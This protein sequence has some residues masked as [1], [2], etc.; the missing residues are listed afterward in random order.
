MALRAI[1]SPEARADVRA[2]DRDPAL[3]ML[4]TFGHFLK[5]ETGDAKQLHGFDPPL[6]RFRAG[7]Y[8]V[9]YRPLATGSIQIVR[10]LNRREA[11]R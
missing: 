4:K 2:I 6:F 10:I 9:I 11:Y 7:D 5:T 1:W 8:R 3:R